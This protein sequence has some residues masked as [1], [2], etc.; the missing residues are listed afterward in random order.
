M[1]SILMKAKRRPNDVEDQYNK[2]WQ[3]RRPCFWPFSIST[4]PIWVFCRFNTDGFLPFHF[5]GIFS[6]CRNEGFRGLFYSLSTRRLSRPFLSLPS[7]SRGNVA[8]V[9]FEGE[10]VCVWVRDRKSV[11]VSERENVK[12]CACVGVKE[13]K[14]FEGEGVKEW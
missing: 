4:K 2:R 1:S 9:T 14:K 7:P 13:S 5:P 6:P 11:C 10:R 8:G 3:T 12:E